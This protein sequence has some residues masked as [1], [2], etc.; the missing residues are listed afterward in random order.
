MTFKNIENLKPEEVDLCIKEKILNTNTYNT[1][2]YS[3]SWACGGPIIERFLIG[4]E[5]NSAWVWYKDRNYG[6]I[7]HT[8][9]DACMKALL[10]SRFPTGEIKI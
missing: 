10:L 2:Q 7:G 4:S 3:R 8:Q 9:L 5:G 6:M 1:P